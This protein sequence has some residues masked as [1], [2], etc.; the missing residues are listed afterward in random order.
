MLEGRYRSDAKKILSGSETVIL[1]SHGYVDEHK[2]NYKLPNVKTI[3]FSSDK[4]FVHSSVY[5]YYRDKNIYSLPEKVDLI[6][7]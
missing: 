1:G 6:F 2:F 3:I 4:I 5:D 7:S